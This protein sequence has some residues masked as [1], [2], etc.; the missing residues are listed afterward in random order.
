MSITIDRNMDKNEERGTRGMDRGLMVTEQQFNDL[1]NRHDRPGPR[2]TSYPTA[3]IFSRVFDASRTEKEIA[4]SLTPGRPEDISLYF[5]F[6]FCDTL[7]YFCGCTTVITRNRDKI[8]EYLSYLKKEIALYASAL[9]PARR[10]VQM[11]WGGGTPTYLSPDEIREIGSEIRTKFRFA[12]DAEISVEVDPRELTEEHLR[13]LRSVGFN[14][15][16]MGVQDFDERVQAAVNRHQGETLTLNVIDWCRDLGFSSINLDLIY[17]LPM[18]TVESFSRT[19]AKVIEV[20]PNRIA[21]YNFAYVPWMKAHQKLINPFQLPS[22]EVKLRLLSRTIDSFIRAGYEYIGMDHFALQDD[23]L[24]V[25]RKNRTLHRN[26]QGYSTRAGLDLFGLGMSSISHFNGNYA[27]NAKTLTGYY[28][29]VDTGR[30]ATEVGYH[31]SSD[32]VVRRHVIMRLMCDL[33]LQFADVERKFNITFP[34]YFADSLSQLGPLEADG[35][36]QTGP[37]SIIVTDAGRLFLRN[38]AMC[39]DAYLTASNRPVTQFSRTV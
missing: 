30:F 5:H 22:P 29:A 1:M 36:I 23:E 11:H 9:G 19:I 14:R 28:A 6:P 3:P 38:I 8:R 13:A 4:L 25:A 10:V 27:Q 26:F 39:F 32:D 37:D 7:C 20:H 15:V 18:Q 21:V 17:G 34:S 33:E 12:P 31:M 35:L 16:S 2:Y 24:T